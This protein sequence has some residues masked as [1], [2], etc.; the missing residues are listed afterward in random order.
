[1][2]SLPERKTNTDSF[3]DRR[4]R[5]RREADRFP[6]PRLHGP[7]VALKAQIAGILLIKEAW[8]FWTR[9]MSAIGEE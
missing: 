9:L 8:K 1:M 3:P 4:K 5:S 6:V 7:W 2:R